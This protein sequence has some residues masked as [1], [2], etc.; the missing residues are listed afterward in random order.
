MGLV[1]V[2]HEQRLSVSSFFRSLV[3]RIFNLRIVIDFCFHFYTSRTYPRQLKIENYDFN[4]NLYPNPASS[5]VLISGIA[6][7]AN[8]ELINILGEV[9]YVANTETKETIIN[10]ND[11]S[12]GTYFIRVS[13]LHGQKTKKLIVR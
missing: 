13:N 6:A 2:P 9:I 10:V 12:A 7:E 11:L 5:E 4:F 1:A 3:L 8:V